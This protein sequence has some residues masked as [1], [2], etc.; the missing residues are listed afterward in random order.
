VN[1][2]QYRSFASFPTITRANSGTFTSGIL[3]GFVSAPTVA[4]GVTLT[5]QTHFLI[6][7]A[8]NAGTITQQIGLD[9]PAL[10]GSGAAGGNIGIRNAASLRQQGSFIPTSSTVTVT[11]NAA[12]VP[13]TNF[14]STLTNSSAATLTVTMATT[15]AV[16]GQLA[17]V[18]IY[19]FSAAAETITWVNTENG[20]ATAPTTS[21]GSTTLPK[22]VFFMFN[23]A[24]TKWRC[25]IL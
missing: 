14:L 20:E 11:S 23:A 2:G 3:V 4:A 7:D 18:R 25:V 12:T 8:A 5:N 15:N 21:N 9:I 1:L 10:A 6:V 19:D 16:D 22:T 17:V 13:V 24:T